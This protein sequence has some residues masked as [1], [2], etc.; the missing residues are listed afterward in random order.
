MEKYISEFI[1][2]I[3]STDMLL[4]RRKFT[5]TQFMK[6]GKDISIMKHTGRF[7]KHKGA[8]LTLDLP[9]IKEHKK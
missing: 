4:R 7:K 1:P 8:S 5:W 9:V 6:K 2:L 3:V